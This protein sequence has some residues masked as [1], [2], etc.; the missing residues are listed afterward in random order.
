M[1]QKF[2]EKLYSN[3]PKKNIDNSRGQKETLFLGNYEGNEYKIK[4][5][6]SCQFKN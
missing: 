5:D 4:K 6:K 1:H 2:E 3:E